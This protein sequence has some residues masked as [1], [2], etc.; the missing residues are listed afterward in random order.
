[1]NRTTTLI[2]LAAVSFVTACA[3]TSNTLQSLSELMSGNFDTASAK[4]SAVSDNRFIDQRIRIQAPEL[5]EYVF[6]QQL[7]QGNALKLYRQRIVV[8]SMN[9]DGSAI[10]SRSYALRSPENYVDA[11]AP[12]FENFSSADIVD[13]MA[14][15]CEQVW[16]PIDHGFRGYVDPKTCKVVSSRTAKLRAIESVNILTQES[17]KLVERGFDAETGKQLFGTPQGQTLTLGRTN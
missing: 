6:Y 13:F 10:T 5:G 17:L 4:D 3:G 16:T 9:P 1:M 8:F 11:K 2:L 7:N 12:D 15:G 14:A